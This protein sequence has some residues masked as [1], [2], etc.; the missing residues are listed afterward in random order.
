ML[1][2]PSRSDITTS[3]KFNPSGAAQARGFFAAALQGLSAVYALAAK[4]TLEG[5]EN[6]ADRRAERRAE[7]LTRGP[8]RGV[9]TRTGPSRPVKA[10]RSAAI[11]Q[12][13]RAPKSR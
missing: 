13:K 4:V 9:A 12:P 3:S 11:S 5:F 10:R 2:Q 6:L 7:R 8:E 1:D